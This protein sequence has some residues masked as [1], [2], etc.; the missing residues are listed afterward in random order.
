MPCTPPGLGLSELCTARA[1]GGGFG[2][3]CLSWPLNTP[4][5]G[6][7]EGMGGLW[8]NSCGTIG[9]VVKTVS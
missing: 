1:S 3:T 2:S 7:G 9:K 6:T 8:E 5:A 4:H